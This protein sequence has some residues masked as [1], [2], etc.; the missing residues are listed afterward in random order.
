MLKLHI[1]FEQLWS[2]YYGIECAMN[3]MIEVHQVI[4]AFYYQNDFCCSPLIT[5]KMKKHM[6]IHI[7]PPFVM[8]NISWEKRYLFIIECVIFYGLSTRFILFFVYG[9]RHWKTVEF[10]NNGGITGTKCNIYHR[11]RLG[12]DWEVE[13]LSDCFRRAIMLYIVLT[14]LTKAHLIR[15]FPRSQVVCLTE[16]NSVWRGTDHL[17]PRQ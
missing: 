11:F 4:V 12:R 13:K 1:N 15:F 9:I 6:R 17:L 16:N 10:T 2:L 3:C 5:Q 14:W 8:V 7:I